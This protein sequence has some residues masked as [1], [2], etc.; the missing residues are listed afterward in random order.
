M[1][2]RNQPLQALK[3]LVAILSL[4]LRRRKRLLVQWMPVR[5]HPIEMALIHKFDA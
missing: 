1:G 4:V 3:A 5:G 2:V